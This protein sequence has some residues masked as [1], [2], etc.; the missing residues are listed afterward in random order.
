MPILKNGANPDK[1]I[2]VQE[3]KDILWKAG[4]QVGSFQKKK[5][6][7]ELPNRRLELWSTAR[8]RQE[9]IKLR[10]LTI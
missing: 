10:N 9:A 2:T 7:I 5:Y 8:L 1:D 4:Y 6:R 3:A